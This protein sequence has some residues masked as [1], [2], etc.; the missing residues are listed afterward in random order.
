[1]NLFLNK[2][3][4]ILVLSAGLLILLVLLYFPSFFGNRS[5]PNVKESNELTQIKTQSKDT[6]LESIN[7]DLDKTNVENIDKE[8]DSIEKE[9]DTAI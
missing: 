8:L 7:N 1:M 9:I 5:I 4:T 3:I 6:S 2:K